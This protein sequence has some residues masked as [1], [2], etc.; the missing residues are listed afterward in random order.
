MLIDFGAARHALSEHS[1]TLMSMMTPGYAPFEQ[2]SA[3]AKQGPYTDL[4]A[5]GATVY[6]CI[7]GKSPADAADR[8]TALTEGVADP[9]V[10]TATLGDGRYSNRLLGAV[11]WML[12][13]RPADRPQTVRDVLEFVGAD[14]GVISQPE[15]VSQSARTVVLRRPGSKVRKLPR[16]SF[17]RRPPGW[18]GAAVIEAVRKAGQR[19]SAV[20]VVRAA[21]EWRARNVQRVHERIDYLGIRVATEGTKLARSYQSSK[22]AQGAA[23]LALLLGIFAAYGYA[24]TRW[25]LQP[26]DTFHDRL[27]DGSRAPQMAVIPA[28]GESPPYGISTHEITFDEYDRFAQ[29]TVR[30]LP[31]DEGWGRGNRPVVNVSWRDAA[32]Y[33]EWLSAQ[34]GRHYR[35]PTEPEWERAARGGV[36]TA[37]WWGRVVGTNR[38]NCANCGSTWDNRLTAPVGSFEANIY[39]L[40]D[41]AGNAAEWTC[42]IAAGTPEA[43]CPGAADAR[44][45]AIRGGSWSDNSESAAVTTR[46]DEKPDFSSSSVG[47]R[48]L[49]ELPQ[50]ATRQ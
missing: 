50:K 34:T 10:A 7:T 21:L 49:A 36:D 42:S 37:F 38:A 44:R 13:L 14:T 18:L 24:Q 47:F 6:R 20:P 19:I 29:E 2:Y 11:D 32:A 43:G 27:R 41:T 45:R 33:A 8:M 26:G 4:Y 40:Y 39:G 15:P 23:R 16:F 31:S 22:R 30:T 3:S 48:V 28:R 1:R 9:F 46:M 35:L 5:M 25:P 17:E 12:Q